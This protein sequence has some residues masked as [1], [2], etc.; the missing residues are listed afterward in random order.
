MISLLYKELREYSTFQ[1]NYKASDDRLATIC[2]SWE[3]SWEEGILIETLEGVETLNLTCI[4]LLLKELV[5][6]HA[7]LNLV[8]KKNANIITGRIDE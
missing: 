4:S 2:F 3:K 7:S 8:E 5:F 6:Q 1:R